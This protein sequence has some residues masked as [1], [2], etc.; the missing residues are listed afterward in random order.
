MQTI[1]MPLKSPATHHNNSSTMWAIIEHW[2]GKD[3]CRVDNTQK[4]LFIMLFKVGLDTLVL[5][6]FRRNLYTFFMNVFSYSLVLVDL[7]LFL[8]ITMV[9][10]L[11]PGQ[12]PVSVCFVL[13][14]G[15]D[16]YAALPLPVL[17][18]GLLNYLFELGNRTCHGSLHS[19]LRN[20]FLTLVVWAMAC[21]WSFHST[22]IDMIEIEYEVGKHAQ[23]CKMQDST[24]M[25]FF[26]AGISMAICFVLLPF[27]SRLPMWLREANRLSVQDS[28]ATL[29]SD[30]YFSKTLFNG[31]RSD[32]KHTLVVETGQEVPPLYV[33]LMLCFTVTWMPFIVISLLCTVMG[34]AVPS[35]ITVNTLWVECA[36]SLLMGI[37]F[38]LKSDN[39]G[40]Y[41]DLSDYANL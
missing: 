9:W 26:F 40:P 39:L 5:T 38:W 20:V 33:S 34:F 6:L 12:S 37:V 22:N 21:L 15:S 10:F 1:Q 13:A 30:L 35:Y 11:G 16:M 31:Q 32:E 7:A 3:S 4:Y 19:G 14:H 36:N 28:S 25:S 8:A 29:K 2:E 23:V 41:M 17:I 24:S 27:C 18:L